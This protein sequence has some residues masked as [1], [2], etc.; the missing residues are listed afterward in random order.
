LLSFSSV[1]SLSL[2]SQARTWSLPCMP[3][4]LQVPSP[5]VTYLVL[6]LP[7]PSLLHPHC[8]I[9]HPGHKVIAWRA[10]EGLVST[11]PTHLP[12]G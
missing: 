1:L 9:P 8:P 3:P 5:P 2:P 12:E 10:S 7:G 11:P 6:P 4:C